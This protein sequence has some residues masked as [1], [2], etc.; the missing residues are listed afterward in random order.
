[1]LAANLSTLASVKPSAA[2]TCSKLG[3]PSA[4][5]CIGARERC[6]C[7]TICAIWD[8]MVCAPTISDRTTRL[9]LVLIVAPM[10]ALEG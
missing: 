4:S 1:M 9:P 8:S 7:A 2:T 10:K 5:R 6:A 3:R